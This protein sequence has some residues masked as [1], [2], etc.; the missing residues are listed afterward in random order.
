MSQTI[1]STRRRFFYVAASAF[2]LVL[3]GGV[4]AAALTPTPP[5]SR[6]PFYPL[7]LPLDKDNDLVRVEGR[8]GFAEGEISNVVGRVLDEKGRP[9]R[10]ARIE[11]WQC[12]ANGRYHHSWDRRNVPLDPHF[13][14]YGQFVTGDDGAY[15]F[16]TI[17]PVPYPGRA[18]HIHFAISGPDFEPLITQMYVAEAPENRWDFLLNTIED[19]KARAS[20]IVP[21]EQTA[22]EGTELLANF[23]IV[24]AADGRFAG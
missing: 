24:L 12:D 23:D 17:K 6:G 8:T 1:D 4:R 21:F 3:A 9:V 22:A 7:R 13:Q 10:A 14:G 2:G 16:R 11:I 5:Q 18:P 19:P 20:V 15:R